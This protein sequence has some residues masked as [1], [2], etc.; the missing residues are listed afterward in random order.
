MSTEYNLKVAL[1]VS[2]VIILFLLLKQNK[3]C[4]MGG[5][6]KLNQNGLALANKLGVLVGNGVGL[7]EPRRML[8]L[9]DGKFLIP[10]LD[11]C[12][13]H[14]GYDTAA[15]QP[16]NPGCHVTC[17][18]GKKCGRGDEGIDSETGLPMNQKCCSREPVPGLSRSQ[19]RKH[20]A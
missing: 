1:G 12:A 8:P 10:I 2:V 14:G 11:E 15:P 5:K 20:V 16:G 13:E 17:G 9:E 3:E 7:H 4:S 19:G 6:V 18:G